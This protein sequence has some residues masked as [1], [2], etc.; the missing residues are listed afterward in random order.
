MVIKDIT[1]S[2]IN[3]ILEK[4][5]LKRYEDILP[6]LFDDYFTYWA[7]REYW[8]REL[9]KS[10]VV[11]RKQ[12]VIG[13]LPFIEK[14]LAEHGFDTENLQIIIMVGQ[15]TTNGHAFKYQDE[16]AVFIP[17]EG[18]ETTRQVDIFVTHEILHALHY[19][20]QP[21]FYFKSREEKDSVLRQLITEG[22]ATFLTKEILDISEGDALWA[23]YLS[24]DEQTEW[25]NS[26]K[27]EKQDIFKEVKELIQSNTTKSNLFYANDSDDIRENRAGYFIGLELIKKI[28]GENGLSKQDLLSIESKQFSRMVM[29]TLS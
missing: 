26:C 27:N 20:A 14:K 7:Q 15:G 19:S 1:D 3:N 18:Y 10:K 2:Y 5:N 17:I 24:H 23:D 16:F 9:D 29:N 8:H 28:A 13:Q 21:D 11:E 4:S 22:L 6:E 12:L 25:M